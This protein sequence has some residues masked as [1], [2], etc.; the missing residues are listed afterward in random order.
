MFFDATA[1]HTTYLGENGFGDTPTY[2]FFNKLPITNANIQTAV[3]A[4][5]ADPT[6]AE[7]TYGNIKNWDTSAVTD[8]SALFKGKDTFN[9]DISGWDVSSVTDMSYMFNGASAFNQP[10]GEW[11]VSKVTSMRSMFYYARIFDQ[12]IGNW[13][14]SKVNDMYGMF[15]RTKAFSQPIGN[16]DVSSVTDMQHMFNYASDFNQLIGN[17]DVSSVTD[18]QYMFSWARFFN[19]P[20]GNW[21]VS[22]VT[23]MSWM[24]DQA[25]VFNQPLDNWDPSSVTH[26]S[27]MFSGAYAYNQPLIHWSIPDNS[28][29]MDMFRHTQMGTNG[30][31]HPRSDTPPLSYFNQVPCFD[32]DTLILSP[33]GNVYIKDLNKGDNIV[34]SNGVKRIL[35]I[36]KKTRLFNNTDN[37]STTMFKMKKTKDMTSDLL[38]TGLHA[39]LLDDLKSYKYY[40]TMEDS[41]D[42]NKMIDGKHTLIAA[43]CNKFEKETEP[44]EHTIYH[45]ALEGEKRRYGIYANGVLMESWDNKQTSM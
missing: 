39:I 15:Q 34:T 13:D 37:I 27:G 6:T 22:K 35:R 20:I 38:V 16:W 9:D 33:T 19:R 8:M 26:F 44:T 36:G 10:I 4:W 43:L 31:I 28:I 7:T 21:N 3:D 17:W 1:Y 40:D 5:I 25:W 30:S 29:L 45:I 14:V 32:Q 18:M 24:F 42:E 41:P 12:P 2:D 23:N 11:D